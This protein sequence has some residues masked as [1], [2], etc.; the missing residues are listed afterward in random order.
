MTFCFPK[1]FNEIP[2]GVYVQRFFTFLDVVALI[3]TPYC[4]SYILALRLRGG[5]ENY[6]DS[7]FICREFNM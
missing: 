3:V 6:I 5:V 4:F 7:S 1:L 2:E